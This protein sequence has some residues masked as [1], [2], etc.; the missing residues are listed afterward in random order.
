VFEGLR[1]FVEGLKAPGVAVT[2]PLEIGGCEAVVHRKDHTVTILGRPARGR[3]HV[4]ADI[5]SLG[6]WLL[7]YNNAPQETEVAVG[8][9]YVRALRAG[10]PAADGVSL[11]LYVEPLVTDLG[12]GM[13]DEA[14]KRQSTF[15]TGPAGLSQGQFHRFVREHLSNIADGP[16]LLGALAKLSL[17]EGQKF[18]LKLE[19]NGLQSYCGGS[20]TT[21]V[22]GSIPA[23]FRV[24]TPFFEVLRG[25]EQFEFDVLVTMTV[26]G[27]GTANFKLDCPG[28]EAA[29]RLAQRAVADTLSG[30]LNAFDDSPW[31]VVV[32]EIDM[33]ERTLAGEMNSRPLEDH[34]ANH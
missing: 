18:E 12:G 13:D 32:G 9:S 20:R 16:L 14:D 23:S 2:T 31:L 30:E 33:V 21:E 22:E 15:A 34:S 25:Q 17:A 4:L 24:S 5:V 26:S 10:D 28:L 29:A 1:D 6:N 27:S 19:P 3:R 8:R 7:R 11:R